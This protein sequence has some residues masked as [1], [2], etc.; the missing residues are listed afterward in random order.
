MELFNNRRLVIATKH[1]KE[2]VIAPIVEKSL[3]VRCFI[4]PS[5]DTDAFGTFSG[6]V[7]RTKDA[8]ETLRQKCL[9]AMEQN[10]CDLA[11]AS[12]GSFGPHPT[13]FFAHADDELVMLIDKKNNLEI[14]ARDISTETNFNGKLVSSHTGLLDFAKSTLFPS[15]ALILKKDQN[16]HSFIRKGIHA[17]KDLLE[18]FDYCIKNFGKAY[19]ETDMR[20]MH[21][22]TRMKVIENIVHKLLANIH[23]CCPQ[24]KMP[25]F[26]V[27][28]SIPGLPCELCNYPT[29]ST[30]YHKFVCDHCNNEVLLKYPNGKEVEDPTFCNFCNP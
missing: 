24:C 1:K 15:H 28:D 25:G 6:E 30:L 26:V 20:A 16:D 3:A 13:M 17:E 10:N 2:K 8:L 4:D 11:I 27:K 18:Y 7:E 29:S 21:N 5:F 12:E 22:P 14:V 9:K 23:S 19:V